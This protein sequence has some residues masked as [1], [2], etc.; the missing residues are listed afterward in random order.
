MNL[1]IFIR[2]KFCLK[3]IRIVDTMVNLLP[4]W[5]IGS[6]KRR[7]AGPKPQPIIGTYA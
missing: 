7:I 5:L 1:K 6:L 4:K 2:P 3:L